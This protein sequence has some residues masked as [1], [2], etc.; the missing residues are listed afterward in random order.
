MRL[1]PT[2]TAAIAS[3]LLVHGAHADDATNGVAPGESTT[4]SSKGAEIPFAFLTD[5]TTPAKNQVNVG[6]GI[7]TASAGAAERPLPADPARGVVHSATFAYGVSARFAPFVTAMWKQGASNGNDGVATGAVGFR[8]Q[9]TDPASAFRFTLVGAAFREFDGV[10]GGSFRA[11]GSYDL[12][13]LR[14]AGNLHVERAFRAG[15]DGLDVL[16]LAGASV[17]V[18]SYLRLGAEYVGQDLEDAFEKNEAEGGAKH[19]AGPS[20]AIDLDSKSGRVQLTG[21]PAFSLAANAK[22]AV[23]GR[24]TLLVAF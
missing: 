17:R 18:A 8:L 12:G 22:G 21:G 24:A 5:P 7:G 23:L 15:R 11:A 13:P 19:W 4:S 3:C 9:L 14:L 16:A 2:F 1:L 20:A 10:P 6:Y